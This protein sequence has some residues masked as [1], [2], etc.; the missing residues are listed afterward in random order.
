VLINAYYSNPFQY[1]PFCNHWPSSCYF[2]FACSDFCFL[3][4][5]ISSCSTAIIVVLLVIAERMSHLLMWTAVVYLIVLG[6]HNLC[7]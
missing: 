5:L 7:F 2:L 3:L 4:S 1:H 6:E